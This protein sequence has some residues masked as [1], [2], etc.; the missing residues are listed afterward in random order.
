MWVLGPCKGRLGW[1]RLEDDAKLWVFYDTFD[2]VP[3]C[4]PHANSRLR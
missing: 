2:D 3:E 4:F 1:A